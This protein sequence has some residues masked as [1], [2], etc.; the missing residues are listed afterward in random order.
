MDNKKQKN[1]TDTTTTDSRKIDREV[2]EVYSWW[3][4]A[5]VAIRRSRIKTWKGVAILAFVAGSVSA[6][7]LN[8][9]MKIQTTSNASGETATLA[10]NPS[11]IT[12]TQGETF[13]V[14]VILNTNNNNVVATRAI[15]DYNTDNFTLMDWDT[16]NS[17]FSVDN[18]C[19]YNGKPCEIVENDTTN[20]KISV[21]LSKPSPGVNTASGE[22]V[23]LTFQAKNTAQT[24]DI[25]LEFNG[26]GSATDS[27][28]ILDG[29]GDNGVGTDILSGVV[30]ATVT[31]NSADTTAP[32]LS[33]VSA[34]ASTTSDNTPSYTF[35]ST[36]AGTISYGGSCRSSRT[37]AT[38]GNNTITFNRLANGT[39]SDC[40]ITVT[41]S[42]GNASQPLTVSTFTVSADNSDHDAPALSNGY[43]SGD[44][45]ADT[46]QVT[47]RVRTNENAD[48]RY[49]MNADSSY[50][51][52]TPFANTGGNNHEVTINNLSPGNSYVYYVK[53]SDGH[54][55]RNNNDYSI[56]FSIKANHMT[57]GEN[58]HQTSINSSDVATVIKSYKDKVD[59]SAARIK[60]GDEKI[61]LKKSKSVYSKNKKI[62]FNG[63]AKGLSGG[64]VQVYVDKKLKY[65]IPLKKKGSWSKKV[66][67]KSGGTHT[68][69]FKYVDASGSVVEESS[70]Y[71]IKIDTKKPKF[72][73]MPYYLV[74]RRG[75]K[76]WWKATDNNKVKYYKYYFNGK[77]V[78]TKRGSFIIPAKTPRGL[79]TLKIKAYDKAGNRAIKYVIINVR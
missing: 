44:L 66:K 11:S 62:K 72:K 71:T 4:N 36:E 70:K 30:N 7:V 5:L 43:P 69:K 50:D 64:M 58:Q 6:L 17:S 45:P 28:V 59:V 3:G 78:K 76:V 60:K 2:K 31:V 51:S 29:Y 52:M 48:C 34:V 21:T 12:V 23:R 74:K 8:V 65:T 25:T 68:V 1:N 15:V 14:D 67:I 77:K 38:A 56:A 32:V 57:G 42:S 63:S 9:S 37:T 16:T 39:Y 75:D 54:G 13:T 35:S 20:G 73:K 22:V 49:S 61:R 40:T 79:H 47:L 27:D 19:V 55:N 53:C 24:D 33:E 10:L 26:S 46:S 41:D 18:S